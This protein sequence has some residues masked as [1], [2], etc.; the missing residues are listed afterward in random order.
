[1][2]VIF[3]ADA[4]L[5]IGTGHV[6]RCLTLADALRVNGAECQFICREHPGNLIEYIRSKEYTTHVLPMKM[7]SS[8][9]SNVREVPFH[10]HWLGTT[11][12][13]DA[14]E[15][16]VILTDQCPDWVIL[17][18]YAVD[19]WWEIALG[20]YCRQLMVVDDLADRSHKC[21]LLLD[22]TFGRVADEYQLL[23]SPECRLLCGAEYALLRP[24]FAELRSYSLGRREH[25]QVQ[26]LLI[27]L[28]GIDKD[29]ATERVMAAL[30]DTGLPSDCRI[31]VVMGSGA[32]WLSEI[33]QRA[34]SMPWRTEV[35]VNVGDMAEL[36]ADSDLAIGAAGTT[37]WERCCLGVPSIVLILADN[38]KMVAERLEEAGAIRTVSPTSRLSEEINTVMSS[39]ISKPEH[40]IAMSR[41]GSSIVDGNGVSNVLRFLES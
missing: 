16:S 6:M 36:M 1:M 13:Q 22:Q 20:Q 7:A 41:A 29:N 38:Q 24:E 17:D 18:H 10:A 8:S 27:A 32:P 21:D 4:S 12:E 39:L 5:L 25:P 19:A 37:S 30:V 15:C 3:R 2:K 40:L 28:G 14:K 11:Q 33:R 35:L 26:H 9:S 23:V 31:T 34:A